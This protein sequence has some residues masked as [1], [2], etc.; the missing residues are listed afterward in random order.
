MKDQITQQNKAKK[1]YV[2]PRVIPKGDIE[3]MTL[4]NK[5]IGVSDGFTF[6][7]V[8]IMNS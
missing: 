6:E 3:K 5:V 8:D 4:I 1:N 7:G 2:E